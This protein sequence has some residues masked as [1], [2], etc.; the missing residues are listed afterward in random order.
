MMIGRIPRTH[1]STRTRPLLDDP[2]R[3]PVEHF[4]RFF[5]SVLVAMDP[6][7]DRRSGA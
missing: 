4:T 1:G 6:G 2:D 3:W 5:G 7:R